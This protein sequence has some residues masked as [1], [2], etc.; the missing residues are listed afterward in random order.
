VDESD[1]DDMSN[2]NGD[3]NSEFPLELL[4]YI[5][6]R[7]DEFARSE[8]FRNRMVFAQISKAL[9]NAGISAWDFHS[10]FLPRLSILVNDV[11]VNVRISVARVFEGICQDEEMRQSL[12]NLD[13]T[14]EDSIRQSRPLDDIKAT[15][16]GNRK[17]R[18]A[19]CCK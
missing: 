16:T 7:V 9:L 6:E 8:R 11:V 15:A 17:R 13:T 2:D 14:K 19:F 18:H 5:M 12:S 3:E 4:S 1:R 10:F